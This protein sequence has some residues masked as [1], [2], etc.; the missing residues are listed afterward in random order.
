MRQAKRTLTLLVLL[1]AAVMLLGACGKK[2]VQDDGSA[3]E[4]ATI[5]EFI[6]IEGGAS[7]DDATMLQTNTRYHGQYVEGEYWVCFKTG[8]EDAA[9]AVT[10]LNRSVGSNDLI[11]RLYD[12]AETVLEPSESNYYD[13]LADS[14]AIAYQDGKASTGWIDELEANTTYYICLTCD[15]KADFSLC[16]TTTEETMPE[17]AL[18]PASRDEALSLATNQEDVALLQVNETYSGKYV[19]GY[20]WIAFKT[21][22]QENEKY[23]VTLLNRSVGSAD[24]VARMYDESGSVWE[25]SERNYD[26]YLSDS[27]AIA[28]Q[29]GKMSTGWSDELKAN[30]TYYLCL[31]CDSKAE[32]SLTIGG[33]G[34]DGSGAADKNSAEGYLNQDGSIEPGSNM[35]AA[36]NVPLNTKVYGKYTG[37]YDWL[38]FTTSDDENADYCLTA[39]NCTVDSADLVGRL[40]DKDGTLLNP[41]SRNY[42]NYLSESVIIA[43]QDGKASTGW[44]EGL[45]PNTRYYVQLESDGKMDYSLLIS[46]R[47]AAE[48]DGYDTSNDLSAVQGKLGENEPF[49]V[50]TNQN[51]ATLLQVNTKYTGS[52]KE[53]FAW[54]AFRTDGSEDTKYSITLENLKADSADLI[55]RLYDVKGTLLKPSERNYDNYLADSISIAYPDGKASTGWITELKPNTTYYLCLNSEHGT[56]FH[57][58]INAPEQ[59]DTGTTME[60]VFET[61]YELNETQVNFVAN[62]AT[63]LYPEQAKAALAP[64]AEIILAHPDLKVLLAGTTAQWGDQESCVTLSNA[65]AQAVKDTLVK[66]FGVPES[67]LLVVGCG[68]ANDPFVRGQ[69][70]DANG[71]FVETEGAKNRRVVV[72]NAETPTAKKLLGG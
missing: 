69:D 35:S 6:D 29:D 26:N 13:Y 30:T 4:A 7:M 60:K 25:P 56:E 48:N 18:A 50:G 68:Y 66:D 32:F 19:D 46:A 16:I 31:T 59:Q 10:L 17:R 1:L 58:T 57:L 54:V 14:F 45:Q 43:Y 67:Q 24:L 5:S 39:V 28:Y 55:A 27:F 64:V 22:G 63:F 33:P 3:E 49:K 41:S 65:R 72:I 2:T 37:G 42:D 8:D 12:E 20:A 9:Y 62:Q 70:V 38:S 11:A 40:F 71:N 51:D 44:L 21:G 47:S 53:G 36:V 61:A 15:S 52:Y 34:G 23:S